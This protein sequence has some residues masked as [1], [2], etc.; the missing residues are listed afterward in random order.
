MKQKI[1]MNCVSCNN[2]TIIE[3]SDFEC[4]QCNKCLEKE[5][6]KMWKGMGV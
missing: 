4:H 6:N 2:L 1:T 5:Y 3:K